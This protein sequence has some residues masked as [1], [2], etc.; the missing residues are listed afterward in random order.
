MSRRSSHINFVLLH[1]ILLLTVGRYYPI[2][3]CFTLLCLR[4]VCFL[5]QARME[6]DDPVHFLM[7]IGPVSASTSPCSCSCSGEKRRGERDSGYLIILSHSLYPTQPLFQ[8]NKNSRNDCYE[9]ET[10]DVAHHTH[11]THES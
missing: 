10:N 1:E 5:T 4:K 11:L 9:R 7:V 8:F 6:I 3:P 2:L